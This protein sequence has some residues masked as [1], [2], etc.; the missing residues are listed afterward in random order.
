MP[1]ARTAMA[2]VLRVRR[3]DGSPAILKCLSE[4]GRRE[5]GAA[6]AVLRAFAGTGAVRLLEADDEV[7]L[8]EHC[9]GPPLLGWPDGH[10]DDIAVPIIADTVSRLH[11]SRAARP[12]AVPTLADRC[13]ALDRAISHEAA[14][15]QARFLRARRIADELLTAQMPVLLHGDLHH[16]NILRAVRPGGAT[17]LAIDPQGVWGDPAYEV[18]NAFG[19]PRGHPEVTLAPGRPRRLASAFAGTLGLDPHRILG[20]AFVHSCIAAAWAIEDGVDP[21]HRVAVADAVASEL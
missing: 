21:G 10:R 16:E 1:L 5:E 4:T 15:H 14:P 19:N 12:A 11:G 7:H 13:T 3:A 18:A 2:L 8:V 17:W 9:A 20:W 6:P